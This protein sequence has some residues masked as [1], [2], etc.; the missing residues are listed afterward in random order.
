MS[1]KAPPRRRRASVEVSRA[2]LLLAY[3]GHP[4]DLGMKTPIVDR[5]V[6]IERKPDIVDGFPVEFGPKQRPV[7]LLPSLSVRPSD[8]YSTCV[9]RGSACPN[10]LLRL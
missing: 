4:F 7:Y 6:L 8:Q 2:A 10:A 3:A 5:L 9:M 1:F